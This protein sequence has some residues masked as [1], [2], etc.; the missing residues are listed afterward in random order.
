MFSFITWY[1]TPATSAND[2]NVC[3]YNM[4]QSSKN[5]SFTAQ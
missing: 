4:S 5:E 2:L 1:D 3:V